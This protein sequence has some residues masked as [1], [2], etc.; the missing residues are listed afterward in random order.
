MDSENSKKRQKKIDRIIKTATK[1]FASKGFDGANINAIAQKS[2]INR[3][4]MF[5]YTG[6][7]ETLYNQ[8]IVR[9]LNNTAKQTKIK[10]YEQLTPEEKIKKFID[11]ISKVANTSDLSLVIIRELLSGGKGLPDSIFNELAKGYNFF[12]E[13][14][15]EGGKTGDFEKTNEILL[16]TMI[17]ATFLFRNLLKPVMQ[18]EKENKRVISAKNFETELIEET[19]R[20]ILKILRK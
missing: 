2:G 7:K 5:Y 17:F 10:L 11:A 20:T 12:A 18:M 9:Q 16:L 3:R 14:I 13:I 8:V 19:T 1:E 4:S 15:E 6:D